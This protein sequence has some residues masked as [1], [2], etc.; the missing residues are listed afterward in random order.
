MVVQQVTLLVRSLFTFVAFTMARYY[1]TAA[2]RNRPPHSLTTETVWPDQQD[3]P[4][5]RVIPRQREREGAR[6]SKRQKWGKRNHLVDLAPWRRIVHDD[7]MAL[8]CP[9]QTRILVLYMDS[10]P[11]CDWFYQSSKMRFVSFRASHSCSTLHLPFPLVPSASMRCPRGR[12]FLAPFHS[13]WP[14]CVPFPRACIRACFVG[15]VPGGE[16]A[17]AFS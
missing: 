16:G 17:E 2:R 11:R 6:G 10:D 3:K 1:E 14:P 4:L 15:S 5:P 12:I 9:L 7:G 8:D 13:C